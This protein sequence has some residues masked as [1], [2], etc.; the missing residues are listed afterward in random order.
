MQYETGNR[1]KRFGN[2][3]H[4]IEDKTIIQSTLRGDYY[5]KKILV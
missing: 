1:L 4:C 5:A 3:P 2:Y